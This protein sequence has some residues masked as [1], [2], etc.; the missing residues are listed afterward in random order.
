MKLG[1]GKTFEMKMKNIANNKKYKSKNN[2]NNE[3]QYRT[4]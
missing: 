2:N 1:K 3:E 4:E